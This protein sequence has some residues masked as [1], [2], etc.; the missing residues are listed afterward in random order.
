MYSGGEQARHGVTFLLEPST[1]QYVEKVIP[2]NERL[3][4]VGLSLIDG[5]NIIQVYAHQQGMSTAEEEEFY[6]QLQEL[7]D[8]MKY[9][10]NVILCRDF[11]GHVGCDRIN[12][13]WNIGMHRIGNR[14]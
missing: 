14:K 3:I 5:V 11:K 7:I 4:S 10:D 9:P 12:Y 6:H 8:E 13:E 2:L 1:E